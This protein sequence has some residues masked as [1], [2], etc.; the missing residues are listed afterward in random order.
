M[1]GFAENKAATNLLP[2]P[3]FFNLLLWPPI[4]FKVLC[5]V[6]VAVVGVAPLYES[7]SVGN[8][9]LVTLH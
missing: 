8:H 3:L 2:C 5:T 7:K 9:Q 6:V 4:L 1:C